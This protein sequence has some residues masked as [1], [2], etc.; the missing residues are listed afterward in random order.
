MLFKELVVTL[1]ILIELNMTHEK[2]RKKCHAK[3]W[4]CFE[5]CWNQSLVLIPC[6]SLIWEAS[7]GFTNRLELFVLRWSCVGQNDGFSVWESLVLQT[8][9]AI[10]EYSTKDK[11]NPL[12]TC[13]ESHA[14][15][16]HTLQANRRHKHQNAFPCQ[17]PRFCH[18]FDWGVQ[19]SSNS[20]SW[21]FLI[22]WT[23]IKMQKWCWSQDR[24][25]TIPI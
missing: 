12:K 6:K 15:P 1:E 19:V 4:A 11:S 18:L 21:S 25:E 17:F 5:T 22:E 7:A 24:H 16:G 8:N 23:S 10:M 14:P 3:S 13:Q 20:I 2:L 9:A